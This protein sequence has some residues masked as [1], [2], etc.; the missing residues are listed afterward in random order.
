MQS[1][2]IS[3][4]E[5]VASAPQQANF[6]KLLFP[7][8]GEWPGHNDPALLDLVPDDWVVVDGASRSLDPARR[9][10]LPAG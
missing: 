2:C 4:P 9:T 5:R 10:H 8:E 3:Y 1:K 6:C 7:S